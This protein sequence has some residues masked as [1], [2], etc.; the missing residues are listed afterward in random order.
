MKAVEGTSTDTV[1]EE[2][3]EGVNINC[4]VGNHFRKGNNDKGKIKWKEDEHMSSPR[5]TSIRH[6]IEREDK[7]KALNRYEQPGMFD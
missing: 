7:Q 5:T 3:E 2:E 1:K 6:V 4:Y